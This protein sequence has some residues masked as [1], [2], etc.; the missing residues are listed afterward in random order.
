MRVVVVGK[1]NNAIRVRALVLAGA[2]GGVV[3]PEFVS[4]GVDVRCHRARAYWNGDSAKAKPTYV[5]PEA[6]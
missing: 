2:C 5:P 1:P 6:L 4:H 3:L